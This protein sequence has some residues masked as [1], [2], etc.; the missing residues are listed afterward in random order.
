[1][2]RKTKVA[3]GMTAPCWS[4]TT[5][6]TVAVDT[7]AKLW[8]ELRTRVVIKKI[9]NRRIVVINV[10]EDGIGAGQYLINRIVPRH[11]KH[12]KFASQFWLSV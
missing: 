5:P 10:A 1:M 4:R 12:L 8:N 9:E 3:L 2:L 6:V 7:W 11:K